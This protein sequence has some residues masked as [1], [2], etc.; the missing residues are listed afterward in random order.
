M[1][2]QWR[3]YTGILRA[4]YNSKTFP[5]LR[6]LFNSKTFN[7][8]CSWSK[9]SVCGP[10]YLEVARGGENVKSWQGPISRLNFP[11]GKFESVCPSALWAF[12]PSNNKILYF[13]HPSTYTDALGLM[14][15]LCTNNPMKILSKIHLIP[16]IIAL[17]YL[18]HGQNIY[19]RL[20]LGRII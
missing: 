6:T 2:R 12:S 3:M 5:F 20:Q 14:M 16:N 10:Q 15:G 7:F 8:S 9:R 11:L 18:K 13:P 17:A 1:W 19:L 4:L